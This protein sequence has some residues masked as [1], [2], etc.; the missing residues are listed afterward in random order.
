MIYNKNIKRLILSVICI[1][2][3]VIACGMPTAA[4]VYPSLGS[5]PVPDTQINTETS[6]EAT[7]RA[8][9]SVWIRSGAGMEYEAVSHAIKDDTLYLTGLYKEATDGGKWMEVKGGWVNA[10]YL[11][12]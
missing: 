2:L 9:G 12:P 4:M 3:S 7:A 5:A 10:R 1:S 8:C 11:C 6:T